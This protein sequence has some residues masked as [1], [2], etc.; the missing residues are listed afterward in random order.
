MPVSGNSAA[1]LPGSILV[2]VAGTAGLSFAAV[3]SQ[4][5]ASGPTNSLASES[6][7]RYSSSAEE[8]EGLSGID[9]APMPYA[10]KCNCRPAK[11]FGRQT[12]TRSPVTTPWRASQAAVRAVRLSRS[13]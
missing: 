8:Y 13:A 6:S 5:G 3:S 11:D 2:T 10:A 9:T 12:A 1:K 7:S 4:L